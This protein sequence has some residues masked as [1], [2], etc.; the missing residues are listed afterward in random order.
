MHHWYRFQR[1]R[2]AGDHG[3]FTVG[4]AA[5]HTSSQAAQ[6]LG[7]SLEFLKMPKLKVIQDVETRW[8][9]THACL[10]RLLYLRPA[11]AM[12]EASIANSSNTCAARIFSDKHWAVVEYIVPLLEP[13]MLVQRALEAEKYVTISLVVPNIQALR[14]GLRDGIEELHAELPAGTPTCKAETR[15]IV[16]PCA[17][18]LFDDF[19]R[20]WGDGS[21]ILQY[22]S[23]PRQQ[24]QGFKRWQLIATALDWRTKNVL[25]GLDEDEKAGLWE[26]VVK[27]TVA[28]V[29]EERREAPGP[30]QASVSAVSV[31]PTGGATESP[32]K[33][34]RLTK[35]MAAMQSQ[36]VNPSAGSGDGNAATDSFK[37]GVVH[38]VQIEVLAF[39]RAGGMVTFN[40]KVDAKGVMKTVYDNPL[41]MWRNK[42]MEFPFL[43]R[44][45]RRVLAIPATQA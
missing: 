1:A 24:P 14:L 34:P 23:G 32:S 39:R 25:Y 45:A 3:A 19:N 42:A 36:S 5:L 29:L 21:A 22:R 30:A 11:I 41:D 43:A 28:L 13:F 31:A 40:E 44:V 33:K 4:G 27:E 35:L 6:R 38:A 17:L 37:D 26:L 7:E 16:L 9:S 12:H 20:R 2:C 18:A 8:W 15:A 10:E